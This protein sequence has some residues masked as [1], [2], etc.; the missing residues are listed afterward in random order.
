MGDS[1]GVFPE[2]SRPVVEQ[3]LRG[4]GFNPNDVVTIDNKGS[5]EL[6]HCI[7]VG[8]LF[9]KV[10]DVLGKPNNRFWLGPFFC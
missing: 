3:F 7:T 4:Y 8:E 2:N 9:T 1:L 6:P 5:R 10:L